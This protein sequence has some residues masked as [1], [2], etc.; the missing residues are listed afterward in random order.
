M[1][2]EVKDHNDVDGLIDFVM[3]R[4]QVPEYGNAH[5]RTMREVFHLG[6]AGSPV[7]AWMAWKDGKPVAKAFTMETD[8]AI[9][10]YAV[11]TRPEARGMGLGRAVCL[12]ALHETDRGR[13]MLGVLHSTPMAVSLYEKMGFKH[14]VPFGFFAKPD[15]FHI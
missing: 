7:R 6:E 2:R 5:L 9:G 12:R 1:I 10:L 8:G 3:W 15:G 4:W 14:V 13:G 11:A